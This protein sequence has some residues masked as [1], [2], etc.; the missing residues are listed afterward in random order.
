[1][2]AV[3]VLPNEQAPDRLD[4]V[5]TECATWEHVIGVLQGLTAE[6]A[7]RMLHIVRIE[8]LPLFLEGMS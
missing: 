2:F 3:I 4:L 1:M 7:W 6:S 8:D 5:T